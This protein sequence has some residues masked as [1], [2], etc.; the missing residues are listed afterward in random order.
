MLKHISFSICFSLWSEIIVVL[1][2]EVSGMVACTCWEEFLCFLK[3][4]FLIICL[5]CVLYLLFLDSGFICS[6]IILMQL[7]GATLY[8]Y[9]EGADKMGTWIRLPACP[10][11]YLMCSADRRP[12]DY[13]ITAKVFYKVSRTT[14][15]Q[16]YTFYK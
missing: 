14:V 6:H 9:T 15:N 1:W 2:R 5:L 7:G 8:I 10:V 11:V 4:A 12:L 13:L 3:G 16:A